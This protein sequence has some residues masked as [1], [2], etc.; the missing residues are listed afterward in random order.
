MTDAEAALKLQKQGRQ[1]ARAQ[2]VA[3][4][5]LKKQYPERYAELYKAALAAIRAR[6]DEE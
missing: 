6:E 2:N 1:R 3:M 5:Q 4:R